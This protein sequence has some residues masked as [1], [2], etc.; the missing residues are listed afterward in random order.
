MKTNLT[1]RVKNKSDDH[2]ETLK[3]KM[4]NEERRGRERSIIAMEKKK[5]FLFKVTREYRF[6]N[7]YN[8][9]GYFESGA[10]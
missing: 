4:N 10:S 3:I 6:C 2:R 9:D 1:M 7:E 8:T 5:T